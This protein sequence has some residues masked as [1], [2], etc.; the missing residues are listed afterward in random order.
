MG[1]QAADSNAA[2]AHAM[3]VTRLLR[4]RDDF[5]A[6]L[7]WLENLDEEA[8]SQYLARVAELKEDLAETEE[9]NDTARGACASQCATTN[10]RCDPPHRRP[11]RWPREAPRSLGP[12]RHVLRVLALVTAHDETAAPGTERT[13]FLHSAG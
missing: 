9:W 12:N 6:Q 5:D 2:A 1:E 8:R 10:S 7:P 13:Q 11:R 3:Q 4:L